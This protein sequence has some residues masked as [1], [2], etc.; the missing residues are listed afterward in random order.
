MNRRT[1]LAF[2]ATLVF[3][4]PLT[5]GGALQPVEVAAIRTLTP[6]ATPCKLEDMTSDG[7]VLFLLDRCGNILRWNPA[8]GQSAS[9]ELED[10]PI[11]IRAMAAGRHRVAVLAGD[12]HTVLAYDQTGRL[13]HRYRYTGTSLPRNIAV[14]DDSVAVTPAYD[15]HLLVL[16]DP[17]HQ[18]PRE[19]VQNPLY[20][21]DASPH[22]SA[23]ADVH[24]DGDR[25]VVV[26][27]QT[28]SVYFVDPTTGTVER[29]DH[30]RHPDVPAFTKPS[31]HWGS[32]KA[33]FPTGVL[34]AVS[35]AVVEGTV[36]LDMV[37][38]RIHAGDASI[39][40]AYLEIARAGPGE[41]A[42][43]TVARLADRFRFAGS[44]DL[45]ILGDT[46]YL[47]MPSKGVVHAVPL[48]PRYHSGTGTTGCGTGP[49]H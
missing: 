16:F 19:L 45:T 22:Y 25:F 7:E 5:F 41:R 33:D 9:I 14:L 49:S 15:A 3:V 26:D 11:T 44:A 36:Y 21:P 37:D 24:P 29:H 10:P 17:V 13:L 46:A 18:H 40:D 30:E 35:S 6:P 8:S 31:G 34:A 1:A 43:T 2:L 4:A 47:L 39:D 32:G 12:A 23:F 42:W 20:W 27:R 28:F 48:G 38:R